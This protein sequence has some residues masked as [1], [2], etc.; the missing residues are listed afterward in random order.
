MASARG[1]GGPPCSACHT[2]RGP[3]GGP[4]CRGLRCQGD[5]SQVERC[6]A[7]QLT[8]PG[9]LSRHRRC[10]I[11]DMVN[12]WTMPPAPSLPPPSPAGSSP[13]GLPRGLRSGP[14]PP[15]CRW[16]PDGLLGRTRRCRPLGHG[17]CG[18]GGRPG[19]LALLQRVQPCG[20]D[21][22]QERRT[23]DQQPGLLFHRSLVG[24]EPRQHVR[25]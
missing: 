18:R 6:H 7:Q 13:G 25:R 4:P 2:H 17:V 8:A 16:L 21:A 22:M 20:D 23:G 11:R 5:G 14:G 9:C 3:H 24:I 1:A 12:T 19:W 10:T 15:G